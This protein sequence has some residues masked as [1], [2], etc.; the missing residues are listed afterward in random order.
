MANPWEKYGSAPTGPVTLG[1]PDPGLAVDNAR[2]QQALTT[3]RAL[4]PLKIKQAQQQQELADIKLREARINLANGGLTKDQRNKLEDQLASVR[5]LNSRIGEISDLYHRN[6]KGVGLGSLAEYAPG[7]MRPV[8]Q[9]FDDAGRSVMGDVAAAFGL[10]AQQQNTPAEME[11]RFGPFIPKASDPDSVIEAKIARLKEISAQQGNLAAGRLGVPAPTVP[12]GM[13][14][15]GFSREVAGMIASGKSM[16]EIVAF[17]AQNNRPFTPEM[18]DGLEK[19]IAAVRAGGSVQTGFTPPSP[20]APPEDRGALDAGGSHFANALLLNQMGEIAGFGDTIGQAFHEG[21]GGRSFKDVLAENIAKQEALLE[22]SSNQHPV[23]SFS[24]EV[25]G[26]LLSSLGVLG[27]GRSLLGRA[28]PRML[29]GGRVASAARTGAGEATFGGIYGS[30]D[31]SGGGRGQNALIGATVAPV[32]SF[33]GGK[34]IE[35]AGRILR[36]TVSPIVQNL[37]DRGIVMSAAQ[38]AAGNG[39]FG[40][41]TRKGVEDALTSFPGWGDAIGAQHNRQLGQFGRAM[42]DEGLSPIGVRVPKNLEGNKAVEF[43]QEAVSNVY[44]EALPGI[45]APLDEPFYVAQDAIKAGVASLPTA[46]REMYDTIYSRAV[47][48]FM[49]KDGAAMSGKS[50]QDIKRGL[51]KQIARLDRTQNPADEYLSDELKNLR[52]TFF[53]WAGRAAPE[54][55][56]MFGNANAAYANLTR[57]NKAASGAKRDGLFTPDGALTA[58]KA[59]ER[60]PARFAAGNAPM[61]SLAQDAAQVLPSTVSDS[62]TPK[63]AIVN[64]LGALAAGGGLSVGLNP[65][66]LAPFGAAAIRHLP[67]MDD[68]LQRVA[69]GERP[70]LIGKTGD[71]LK[72]NARIGGMFGAPLALQYTPVN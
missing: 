33:L 22:N 21:L 54:R 26:G 34:T 8:N 67:G 65:L 69:M 13:V 57:I 1:Q 25:G 6:F 61:Q 46:Q 45:H 28:A 72:R 48:P 31:A 41:Q 19:G 16:P 4:D 11:I 66:A 62:G 9:T 44:D 42:I 58:I 60:N 12:G 15:D 52:G 39:R 35:G 40:G 2:D 24:G 5:G 47:E 38:R 43:A 17:A 30:G 36:P 68:L 20:P 37:A 51:D 10:S 59:G 49:P 55:A 7:F 71:V 3:S 18:L 63:R 23:A 70:N 32:A 53:D 27:A 14:Q 56:E 50:L 29:G 64:G